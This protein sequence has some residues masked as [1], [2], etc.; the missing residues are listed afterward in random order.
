M[1]SI[2]FGPYDQRHAKTGLEMY[3]VWSKAVFPNLVY[4]TNPKFS[5]YTP[6]RWHATILVYI[7]R[8]SLTLFF[9]RSCSD[10]DEILHKCAYK[11]KGQVTLNLLFLLYYQCK[12]P[13]IIVRQYDQGAS[14]I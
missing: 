6:P 10:L 14:R 7:L 5:F 9:L 2:V 8:L 11:T 1:L 13:S 12:N 3:F 4:E